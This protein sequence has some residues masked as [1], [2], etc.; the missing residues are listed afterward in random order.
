M[1]NSD[2]LMT[3]R[4]V[5][6]RLRIS[7]PTLDRMVREGTFP[8]PARVTERVHRWRAADVD[9]WLADRIEAEMTGQDTAR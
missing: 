3:R 9:A 1:T 4:E 7:R 2:P 8:A 6:A 5:C